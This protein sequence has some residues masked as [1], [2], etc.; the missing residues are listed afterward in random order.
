MIAPYLEG[1]DVEG[2]LIGLPQTL[3]YR[4]LRGFDNTSYGGIPDVLMLTHWVVASFLFF[5]MLY[6]LALGKKGAG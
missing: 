6:H 4:E 2:W 1:T 3:A 5:G